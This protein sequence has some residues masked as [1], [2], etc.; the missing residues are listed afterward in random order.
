MIKL[1]QYFLKKCT[2]HVTF[3]MLLMMSPDKRDLTNKGVL[4]NAEVT[5]ILLRFVRNI[6]AADWMDPNSV[7]YSY[8]P[9]P[10]IIVP[11]IRQSM[12]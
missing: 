4:A 7:I 8:Q 2:G 10:N 5:V 3:R 11:L 9:L 6:G 12:M 1:E